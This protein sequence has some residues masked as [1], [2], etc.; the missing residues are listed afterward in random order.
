MAMPCPLSESRSKESATNKQG[1]PPYLLDLRDDQAHASLTSAKYDVFRPGLAKRPGW[2]RHFSGNTMSARPTI[3]PN[4]A[5][6]LGPMDPI[7]I[8]VDS[9]AEM[10]HWVRELGRPAAQLKA[11]VQAVG[12]LVSDVREFLQRRA[13]YRLMR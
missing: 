13:L 8:D 3:T 2:R 6:L 11:A 4:D 7:R 12:P 1:R 5:R 10:R 9:P